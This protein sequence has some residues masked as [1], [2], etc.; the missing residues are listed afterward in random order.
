MRCPLRPERTTLVDIGSGLG[1]VVLHAARRPFRQ[2]IGVEISAA[3]H[4]VAR[5][6]RAAFRGDLACRDIRLVRADAAG[7]TFPRGD[8]LVYL[9][10]PF[11]VEILGPLL[12][13][14]CGD[15][16]REVVL[17]YHTPVER[18]VID[19]HPAFQLIS[20]WDSGSS[21][22]FAEKSMTGGVSSPEHEEIRDPRF[23][24]PGPCRARCRRL[25]R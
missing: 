4:E 20:M 17:V 23:C 22:R 5:D 10:N 15:P 24:R 7:F 2:I 21:T 6:N 18:A 25:L 8:L 13:R 19:A 12:E 11:R 1:R 3:L 14:L 16:G 9:Y